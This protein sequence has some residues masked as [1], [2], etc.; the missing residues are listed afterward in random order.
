MYNKKNKIMF[1]STLRG[2]GI[3]KGWRVEYLKL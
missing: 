1:L 3:D 2:Q